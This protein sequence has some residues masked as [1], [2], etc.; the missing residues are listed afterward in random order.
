MGLSFVQRK[1][2]GDFCMFW[3]NYVL[4]AEQKTNMPQKFSFQKK[5]RETICHHLSFRWTLSWQSSS[6]QIP[7]PVL[8][9]DNKGPKFLL[10]TSVTHRTRTQVWFDLTSW[11]KTV[12]SWSSVNE[13]IQ[14]KDQLCICCVRTYSEHAL[15]YGNQGF[16]LQRRF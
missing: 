3:S 7:S 16:I 13:Y 6:E 14:Q 15:N 1:H 11:N 2:K 8:T 5:Q 9:L 4:S 10:Y 12:H